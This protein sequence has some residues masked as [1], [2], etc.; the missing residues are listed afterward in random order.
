MKPMKKLVFC[1]LGALILLASGVYIYSKEKLPEAIALNTKGQPTIGF[2][3][4]KVQVVVFEEPKCPNCKL[5]NEEVFPK[6]KEQFI[7]TN[8]IRYTMIPVS[9][10]PGSMPAATALLCVYYMN[11]RYPNSE[12]Y[13]TYFNYIFNH[14]P[15]EHQ[16]WATIDRLVDFAKNASPAINL[17]KLKG[18]VET[19]AYRIYV[20]Q[21]N[22][23][24]KKIMNG[25]LST[26]MLYVDGIEVKEL[27]Y[28]KVKKLIKEVLEQKGVY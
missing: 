9:F 24:G 22:E 4:A 13:F 27:S 20:E 17:Q 26:P 2:S 12:L 21:N 18:C 6:L 11:P 16:D 1:T 19:E 8:K 7:D 3:K 25:T 15:P 5:F 23:Y 28:K 10:L 14:Q